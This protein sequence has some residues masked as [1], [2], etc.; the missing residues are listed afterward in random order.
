MT[1]GAFLTG[2]ALDGTPHFH[3]EVTLSAR[4]MESMA[5]LREVQRRVP[6]LLY[7]LS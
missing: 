5:R 7:V 3:K 6:E 4:H 1:D 2:S